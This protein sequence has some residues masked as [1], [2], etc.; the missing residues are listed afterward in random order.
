VSERV[1]RI[2]RRYIIWR[3]SSRPRGSTPRSHLAPQP[4]SPSSPSSIPLVFYIRQTKEH[5]CTRARQVSHD[6]PCLS[7]SLSFSLFPTADS[8][9][10]CV[11]M[12]RQN[13]A[14]ASELRYGFRAKNPHD[15][16]NY[17]LKRKP[18]LVYCLHLRVCFHKNS[19]VFSSPRRRRV[20]SEELARNFHPM[21][22]T[23]LDR[24][25][26]LIRALILA[27]LISLVS[28]S[29]MHLDHNANAA[30][31]YPPALLIPEEIRE[32]GG[33]LHR[34]ALVDDERGGGRRRRGPSACNVRI[35]GLQRAMLMHRA[36]HRRG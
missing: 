12:S 27:G 16:V 29:R 25:P 6:V 15:Y 19:G 1:T 20:R 28:I 18:C 3:G 21:I 32:S 10:S 22:L 8:L 7:L 5:V 4:L 30:R 2:G 9:D 24:V 31:N 11:S 17:L 13:P 14:S 36:Q 33:V 34:R 26:L 23:A 35:S